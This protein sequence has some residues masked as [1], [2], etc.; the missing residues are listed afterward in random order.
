VFSIGNALRGILRSAFIS[1]RDRQVARWFVT[2]HDRTRRF[3]QIRTTKMC[4]TLRSMRYGDGIALEF[5]II[6]YV[7][8]ML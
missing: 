3:I 6:E 2:E 7:K 4:N 5:K 8:S 1:W